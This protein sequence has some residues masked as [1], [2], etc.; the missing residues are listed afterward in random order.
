MR[1]EAASSRFLALAD[2][3]PLLLQSLAHGRHL[4]AHTRTHRPSRK[5]TPPVGVGSLLLRARRSIA[6]Q[7][8]EDTEGGGPRG[9]DGGKKMGGRKR[10]LCA[11]ASG[12]V[13]SVVVHAAA[14]A[15]DRDGARLVLSPSEEGEFPRPKHLWATAGYRGAALREWI[16]ERL[17]PSSE[18][19]VQ[20]RRR[21]WVWV[22]KDVEPEPLPEG[23]EVIERRW[24]AERTPRGSHATG[25]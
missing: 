22:P 20:R 9:H 12:L 2:R 25:G 15:A 10:H 4:G 11:D 19:I 24:V 23:F 14:G 7:T 5:A 8:D 18:E 1:L 21:R 16:I 6:P 17:G 3:L 13:L